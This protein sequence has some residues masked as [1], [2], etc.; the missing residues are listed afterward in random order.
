MSNNLRVVYDNILD[1]P[2]TSIVVSSTASSSTIPANLKLNTK[3]L[4]WRSATTSSTV[5]TTR[6][7]MSI[8]FGTHNTISCIIFAFTNFS[9][10]ATAR[11]KLYSGGGV[12]NLGG[13][14]DNPTVGNSAGNTLVYDSGSTEIPLVKYVDIDSFDWGFSPLGITG[15]QSYK[16]YSV[17]WLPI[18]AQLPFNSMAIQ[19]YDSGCTDHYIQISRLI[20]GNHWSPTYNTGFG[21]STIFNDMSTKERSES[22]DLITIQGNSYSSI[23]FDLHYMDY[24]DRSIFNEIVKSKGIKQP[25]FISL[26]PENSSDYVK[27]NMYQIYGKLAQASEISH[28]VFETY[29]SRVEIEEI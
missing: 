12:P 20:M 28:P 15:Y 16:N 8:R 22:G 4:V 11:I 14:V 9:A 24:R 21:L 7:N 27:E 25:I 3:G 5:G 17:I 18:E 19:V 6:A 29:S 2:D 23:S 26:F 13:T 10:E 1:R